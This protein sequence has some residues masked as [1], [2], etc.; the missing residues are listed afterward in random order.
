MPA[1]KAKVNSE[2]LELSDFCLIVVE[3]HLGVG[4]TDGV[5]ASQ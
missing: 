3:G 2:T 5:T 4:L 1:T